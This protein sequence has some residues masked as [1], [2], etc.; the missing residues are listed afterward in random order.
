MFFSELYKF[1]LIV[2]IALVIVTIVAMVFFFKRKPCSFS[3]LLLGL[4][5]TPVSAA[6]VEI[7][8][9]TAFAADPGFVEVWF[10]GTLLTVF[11]YSGPFMT[12]SIIAYTVTKEK[13]IMQV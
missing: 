7:A 13:N 10:I 9:A 6:F 3:A 8:L 2:A 12:I 5:I 11:F 1:D 4:L